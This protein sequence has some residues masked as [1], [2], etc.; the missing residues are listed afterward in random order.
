[1]SRRPAIDRRPGAKALVVG[2]ALLLAGLL[3]LVALASGGELDGSGA[4]GDGGGLPPGAYGYLYALFLALGVLA[5]P[6]FVFIYARE[7]PY[8]AKR[9]RRARLAPFM[10]LGLLALVLL[11]AERW[12]DGFSTALDRLSI[13]D[14]EDGTGRGAAQP[15]TPARTPF[16]IV[17]GS[18]FGLLALVIAWHLFRPRRGVLRRVPSLAETLADALAVTLDDLRAEPDPRRAIIL[19]YARMETTLTRGGVPRQES[20]APLEYV[21]RVLLE[22]DVRPGP[23]HRLTDLFEQAKF[24]DHPIDGGMKED[25][26]E[27]FEDVRA[28]LRELG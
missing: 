27:A 13:F 14:S 19:A 10:L 17:W 2:F 26:L 12:P 18:V 24:S 5:L 11:L 9:R 16:A 8:S 23:V 1:M 15:P 28:D 4:T 7:T 6:F 21:S 3:A 22:L 20:E 25:A